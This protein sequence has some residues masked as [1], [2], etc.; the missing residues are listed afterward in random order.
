MKLK[1]KIFIAT[2]LSCGIITSV[3]ATPPNAKIVTPPKINYEDYDITTNPLFATYNDSEIYITYDASTIENP[4]D[5]DII[6]IDKREEQDIQIDKSYR[7]NDI[8]TKLAIIDLILTYNELYPSDD[9]WIRSKWSMLNEWNS[10]NLAYYFDYKRA[11]SESVDFENS[12]E[13]QYDVIKLVKK[14]TNKK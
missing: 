10:H 6:I 9:P 1:C 7:I 4:D 8:Q 5:D 13:E 14:M 12:E 2:I 11:Q 3:K